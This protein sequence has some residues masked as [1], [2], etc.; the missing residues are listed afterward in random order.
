MQYQ[1][2]FLYSENSGSCGEEHSRAAKDAGQSWVFKRFAEIGSDFQ[3]VQQNMLI[4]LFSI[5][6]TLTRADTR[7]EFI[8]GKDPKFYDDKSNNNNSDN[9]SWRK[10]RYNHA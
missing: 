5:Y 2:Y 3:T 8:V 9:A 1:C 4:N 6:D 7:H 10:I